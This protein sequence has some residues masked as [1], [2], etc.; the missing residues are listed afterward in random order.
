M[1]Y[2]ESK[3]AKNAFQ[4]VRTG[5]EK[6]LKKH[7]NRS[8]NI[9][10]QDA[11]GSTL[12]NVAVQLSH[13]SVCKCLVMHGAN[14][15]IPDANGV[16]PL[17]KAASQN[18]EEIIQLFVNSGADINCN[19]N[20][21]GRTPL[22][23]ATFNGNE[24]ITEL[25]ITNG[26]DVN[27]ADKHGRTP[28][29][30]AAQKGHENLVQLL[31]DHKADCTKRDEAYATPLM[32]A[33]Q[34][35]YVNVV[36][37]L[38]RTFCKMYKI[39]VN[40]KDSSGSCHTSEDEFKLN[41]NKKGKGKEVDEAINMNSGGRSTK[42]KPEKKKKE[43]VAGRGVKRRKGRVKGTDNKKNNKGKE[44]LA[45]SSQINLSSSNVIPDPLTPAAPCTKDVG[46]SS[47][48]TTSITASR[49]KPD[50]DPLSL[51]RICFDKSA[52]TVLMDCGHIATCLLCSQY[53]QHCPICASPIEKVSKVYIS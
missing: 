35:K 24:K 27:I 34:E 49:N 38:E 45:A 32:K 47:V 2:S 50:V 53:L 22:I 17:F 10:V 29:H 16:T 14:P 25:L 51:C 36:K 37:L 31:L 1:G 40:M 28:L 18:E 11:E 8:N 20:P 19:R 44:V 3:F 21:E 13:K 30:W 43:T 7:L 33:K 39:E 42:R 4:A 9:N 5:N 6:Q 26:A 52:D 23:E 15:N 12:L 46:P 48:G 41:I